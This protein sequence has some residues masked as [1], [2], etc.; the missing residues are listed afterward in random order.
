MDTREKSVRLLREATEGPN[1][2]IRYAD[3]QDWLTVVLYAQCC[4]ALK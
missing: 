4:E 3:L 2:A 1:R